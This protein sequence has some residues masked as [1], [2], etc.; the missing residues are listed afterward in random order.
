MTRVIVSGDD[1]VEYVH[2]KIGIRQG[3]GSSGGKQAD[4]FRMT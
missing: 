2:A 3:K 4:E 1:I